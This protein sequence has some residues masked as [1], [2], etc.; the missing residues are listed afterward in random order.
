MNT[1]NR[2]F[3]TILSNEQTT[4]LFAR[5][6]LNNYKIAM[7]VYSISP[8]CGPSSGGTIISIIGTAFK[9]TQ[10]MKLKFTY[11]EDTLIL[12]QVL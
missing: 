6:Q 4:V 12:T 8:K 7:R 2:R 9:Y 10:Q 11:Q 5:T 3:N 1:E